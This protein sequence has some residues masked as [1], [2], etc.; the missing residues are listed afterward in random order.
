MDALDY[1]GNALSRLSRFQE[2]IE[3]CD[4]I[5]KIDP[6]NVSVL[7]NKINALNKISKS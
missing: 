1:K 3:V 6:K 4:E 5:L 2:V 7:N